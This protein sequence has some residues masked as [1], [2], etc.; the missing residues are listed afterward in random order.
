M[1]TL[2]TLIV[3]T[4]TRKEIEIRQLQGMHLKA[5]EKAIKE[6]AHAYV[7]QVEEALVE[8]IHNGDTAFLGMHRSQA[9]FKTFLRT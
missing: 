6:A 5:W 4:G 8:I 1:I 3:R 2:D 9:E 7:D